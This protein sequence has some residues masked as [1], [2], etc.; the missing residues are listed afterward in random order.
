MCNFGTYYCRH[1]GFS[2]NLPKLCNFYEFLSKTSGLDQLLKKQPEKCKKWPPLGFYSGLPKNV[3]KSLILYGKFA[4]NQASRNRW[5]RILWNLSSISCDLM[6]NPWHIL[7][8]RKI[9]IFDKINENKPKS[10][11]VQKVTIWWKSL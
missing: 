6:K 2:Q 10:T 4:S 5:G 3:Q 9:I 8:P 11:K 1:R 7:W